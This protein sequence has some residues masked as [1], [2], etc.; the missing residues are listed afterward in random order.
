MRRL[1][2][3][4]SFGI[5]VLG[6]PINLYSQQDSTSVLDSDTIYPQED[7]VYTAMR[8]ESKVGSTPK[9][10]TLITQEDIQNSN[11]LNFTELLSNVAGVH[12]VGGNQNPGAGVQSLFLRNNNSNHVVIMVDGVRITDQS[13]P[14]NAPNLAELSL[15]DVDRIEVVRGTHSTLYGS[16]AVG[17]V[18]NII[19]KKSNQTG[20]HGTGSVQV[21]TFGDN[22]FA[23]TENANL[24]YRFKSGVY[25]SGSMM[26]QDVQGIDATVD[27]ITD[28]SVY[29][30]RDNDDFNRLDLIGKVG[31]RNDKID[32][33]AYY[34]VND[35]TAD[36]D[37]GAYRDDNNY[38][39][40]F[41]RKSINAGVTYYP[42][43]KVA[44][45][46]TGGFSK[47]HRYLDNDS[48]VVDAAGNYDSSV[49][50]QTNEG[51]SSTRRLQF[52]YETSAF[53]LIAGIDSYDES[54]YSNTFSYSVWGPYESNNENE[55]LNIYMN[56]LF[57]HTTV[58]GSLLSESLKFLKLTGGGRLVNHSQYGV[59][60]TYE[61][62][63]SYQITNELFGYVNFGSAFNAPSIYQ[64][65]DSF[66]G[67]ADLKPEESTNIEVGLKYNKPGKLF[68]A[69][70]YFNSKI[71]NAVEYVNLYD[72]SKPIDSLGPFDFPEA[73]TYINVSEL[74]NS[75]FEV[76]FKI[77]PTK[78]LSV[79][80]NVTA[81]NS[82]MVFSSDNVPQANQ[83]TNHVEVANIG[84]FFTDEDFK[85]SELVRRP[86]VRFNLAASYLVN[87]HLNLGVNFRHVGNRSS[88][89]TYG[90]TTTSTIPA[91]N[92]LDF[93]LGYKLSK[94]SM[95]R[96]RLEN[97]L[98]V[99]Y[100]EI[101]GYQ[102]R[103]FGAYLKFSYNF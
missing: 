70:S 40:E 15:A 44:I 75:G 56:G 51:L 19:T 28:P 65:F 29:N 99:K 24:S 88:I 82:E 97:I 91:Y 32:A 37:A 6:V 30:Q 89:N 55:D 50:L 60:Y 58:Q 49:L 63:P 57:A 16:S 94:E 21:G 12:V 48:S 71:K 101:L 52:D 41:N 34:K 102:S 9:S 1:S 45:S 22:S 38:I 23:L 18:V 11:Y 77:Q 80:G 43:D 79:L 78:Q 7:I 66:S 84:V 103:G 3:L 27:T 98:N 72:D 83:D 61:V 13:S 54:F 20:L 64:L 33:Y 67:N 35:Q 92:L 74:N 87:D 90:T 86:N 42:S 47:I 14:G 62:I 25:L 36:I 10:V 8:S 93:S 53:R 46:Y 17:G 4:F 5:G 26:N 76:E 39:S 100:S 96:L 81:I 31:Y 68:V 85:I 69:A 95:V 2:I 73:S 59:N